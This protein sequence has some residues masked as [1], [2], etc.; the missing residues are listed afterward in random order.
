MISIARTLGA[1][2]TVPAGNVA[3]S[4]STALAPVAELAGDLAGEVHHMG[5]TLEHHQ[6][7]HAARCR[8]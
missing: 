1:P 5:V 7:F 4:T 2:L 3:R 6:L 8:T